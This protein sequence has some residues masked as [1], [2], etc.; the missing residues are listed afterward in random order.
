MISMTCE[1]W[2]FLIFGVSIDN[3][4]TDENFD[5]GDFFS[6]L[7]KYIAILASITN[8]NA[9]KFNFKIDPDRHIRLQNAF[10]SNVSIQ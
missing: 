2:Q 6:L 5:T 3:I 10:Y 7:P 1:K 4:D 8:I 9:T